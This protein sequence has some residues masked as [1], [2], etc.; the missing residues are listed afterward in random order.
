V[1]FPPHSTSRR[2]QMKWAQSLRMLP[3]ID[4]RPYSTAPAICTSLNRRVPG[5]GFD[6]ASPAGLP[7]ED[8]TVAAWAIT[9]TDVGRRDTSYQRGFPMAPGDESPVDRGHLIPHLSGGEFGPNIFRQDSALNRGWSDQ[10]SSIRRS[11][12]LQRERRSAVLRALAI[13]RRN[14]LPQTDRDRR[15]GARYNVAP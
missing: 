11:S 2:I 4:T 15:P 1:P 13:R 10:G 3:L 14:R 8:R 5:T 9:S 7:Q 6:L 12:V